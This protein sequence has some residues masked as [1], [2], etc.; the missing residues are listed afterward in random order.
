MLKIYS[1]NNILYIIQGVNYLYRMS[2][3]M[4]IVSTIQAGGEGIEHD[5][6]C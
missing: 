4:D 3:N 2:I 5:F 6:R 1:L